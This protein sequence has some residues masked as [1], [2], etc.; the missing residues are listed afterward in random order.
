ML[1]LQVC[2]IMSSLCSAGDQTQGLI[3][4]S[5]ALYQL[6]STSSPDPFDFQTTYVFACK[7]LQLPFQSRTFKITRVA[8]LLSWLYFLRTQPPS[9]KLIDLRLTDLA[10]VSELTNS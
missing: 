3:H 8:V 10:F 7:R 5:H 1:R 9:L 6:C 2:I 4:L